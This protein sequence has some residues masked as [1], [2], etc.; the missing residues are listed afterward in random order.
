VNKKVLQF[1]I[2]FLLLIAAIAAVFI[3]LT[4]DEDSSN[5]QDNVD[6]QDTRDLDVSLQE[7]FDALGIDV[8]VENYTV[9]SDSSVTINYTYNISNDTNYNFENVYIVNNLLQNFSPVDYEVNSLTSET[10][11]ALNPN[12]D[13][14]SNTNLLPEGFEMSAF[15]SHQ[16]SLAVT[17][18]PDTGETG[19][20]TN[21]ADIFG[22]VVSADPDPVGGNVD[23]G[24]GSTGEGDATGSDPDPIDITVPTD[25]KFYLVDADSDVIIKEIVNGEQINLADMPTDNL[26]I[27][28]VAIDGNGQSIVFDLDGQLGYRIENYAPYAISENINGDFY[29]AGLESGSHTLTANIFSENNGE[30][31]LLIAET[32]NFEIIGEFANSPYSSDS[33]SVSLIIENDSDSNVADAQTSPGIQQDSSSQTQNVSSSDGL[34]QTGFNANIGKILFAFSI[35]FIVFLSLE[36]KMLTNGN[37]FKRNSNK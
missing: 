3:A 6:S 32:I 33:D 22:D 25:I 10:I 36:L 8:D 2:I 15:E 20:F 12:F 35:C 9:N 13:G 27:I 24:D 14:D 31:D 34:A 28:A 37:T 26:T 4:I 1:T 18:Y 7:A 23:S 5:I 30:G 29:S 16:I 17:I 21:S 19:P 11:S